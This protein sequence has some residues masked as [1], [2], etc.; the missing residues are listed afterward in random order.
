MGRFEIGSQG[1]IMIR[2]NTPI[3]AKQTAMITAAVTFVL[4]F[5]AGVGFVRFLKQIR[6]QALLPIRPQALTIRKNRVLLLL[7]L[8]NFY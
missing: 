7:E 5:F 3:I 6:L 4:G 1:K 2:D 8:P